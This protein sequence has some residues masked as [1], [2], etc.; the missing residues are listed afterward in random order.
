M[1]EPNNQTGPGDSTPNFDW[2]RGQDAP[3]DAPWLAPGGQ[4]SALDMLPPE[5]QPEALEAAAQQAG[6]EPSFAAT[7]PLPAID[8]EPEP[9]VQWTAEVN[10][11]S[12][13]PAAPAVRPPPQPAAAVTPLPVR[14]AGG[15]PHDVRPARSPVP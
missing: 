11:P 14:H 5:E 10:P 1:A 2:L 4:D 3:A 12:R 8:D 6:D 9:T 13:T 15:D 7:E